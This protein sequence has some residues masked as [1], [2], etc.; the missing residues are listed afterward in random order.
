[1][2]KTIS[3]TTLATIKSKSKISATSFAINVPLVVVI[4]LLGWQQYHAIGAYIGGLLGFTAGIMIEIRLIAWQLGIPYG[5][6]VVCR[7]LKERGSIE[8]LCNRILHAYAIIHQSPH[9]TPHITDKL[10]KDLIKGLNALSIFPARQNYQTYE[11]SFTNIVNKLMNIS[12]KCQQSDSDYNEIAKSLLTLNRDA[13]I[14]Y[15]SILREIFGKR[16]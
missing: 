15:D 13:K 3:I 9:N 8:K 4:A 14:Y 11:D 16:R 7:T 2:K 1:M 6:M 5:M 12:D 10:F